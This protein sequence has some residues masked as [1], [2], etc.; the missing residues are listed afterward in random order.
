[1]KYQANNPRNMG[2]LKAH[3]L[4]CNLNNKHTAYLNDHYCV[5]LKEREEPIRIE[6][7]GKV[8]VF[9]KGYD[10]YL[11]T[12]YRLA[13]LVGWEFWKDYNECK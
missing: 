4:R 11:E 6:R 3:T 12:F 13:Y 8:T 10:K 9:E 2:I 5:L 1:M 7:T